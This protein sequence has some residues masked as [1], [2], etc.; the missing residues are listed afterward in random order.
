MVNKAIV[1]I[2]VLIVLTSLGVGVLIGTQLGGGDAT[3]VPDTDASDGSATGG[4]GDATT[5]T[6]TASNE[7]ATAVESTETATATA[8]PVQTT[9][10]AREFDSEA[11]EREVLAAI[12]EKRTERELETFRNDT[13]TWQRLQTMVRSHSQAMAQERS[14]TFSAGG[15]SSSDRYENAGL[16]GRCQYQDPETGDIIQPSNSFQA[17]GSTVAGQSYQEDGQRRFNGN[18]S[19]VATTLV[20]NWFDSS[21]Y[22]PSLINRGVELLAVGVTVTDDGTVYAATAICE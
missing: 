15:N 12:N 17:V 2:L 1:G 11:I 9:V 21:T 13:T 4:G 5:S 3:A 8:T 16:Y 19:Q 10:P 6:A 22:R 14:V 20:E 7:T 18:E